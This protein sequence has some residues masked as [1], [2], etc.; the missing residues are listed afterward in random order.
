MN[1]RGVEIKV[2]IQLLDH[3]C[4][5]IAALACVGVRVKKAGEFGG[6]IDPNFALVDDDI[7]VKGSYKWGKH[8]DVKKEEILILT[9]DSDI[10]QYYQDKFESIWNF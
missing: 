10:I 2:L 1:Y 3:H 8:Q 6:Q 9:V 7:V 5:L 4:E